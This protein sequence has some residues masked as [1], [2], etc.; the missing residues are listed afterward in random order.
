MFTGAINATTVAGENGVPSKWSY[1]L[2]SP[3]SIILD[4]FEN[5]YIMD[6]RN[7]RIQRWSPGSTYGITILSGTFSNPYGIAFDRSGNLAI[8]DS[9]YNRVVLSPMICRE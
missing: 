3:T 1:G 6:S 9:S 7:N 4:Q 2:N 5:M 8:A